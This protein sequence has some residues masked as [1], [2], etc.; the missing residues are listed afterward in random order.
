MALLPIVAGK[1]GDQFDVAAASSGHPLGSLMLFPDGRRFKYGRAAATQIATGLLCQ[2]TLNDANWDELVVPTARA[3]GDRVVSLT[4]GTAVITVDLFK[5]GYLNVDDDTGEGYEYTISSNSAAGNAGTLTV[6]LREALQVAW[7]VATT[8][9]VFAHPYGRVIVCP[10]SQATAMIVGVTP[11]VLPASNYGWLQT[12]GPCSVLTDTQSDAKPPV[13]NEQV[14][15]SP[16]VAGAVTA[17]SSTG[18]GEEFYVGVTM[19][20]SADTE[21]GIVCLR[22]AH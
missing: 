7:T 4:N 15:D 20:V 9:T 13:I 18:A 22:I 12:W 6:N 2:Q 21:Y 8:V 16:A 10:S 11:C 14:I 5:D 17:T 1:P 19:E 3:I